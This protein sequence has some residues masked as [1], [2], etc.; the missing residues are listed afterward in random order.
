MN[1]PTM[2]LAPPRRAGRRFFEPAQGTPPP[3]LPAREVWAA[4]KREPTVRVR[5]LIIEAYLPLLRTIA[6]GVYKRLPA[7]V[8]LEELVS[9]GLF[10]LMDA[11]NAYDPERK[12]RFSTFCSRRVRGSIIDELRLMDLP[13]RQVREHEAMVKKVCDSFLKEFGRPPCDDEVLT[14]LGVEPREA[15]KILRNGRVTHVS[16]LSEPTGGGW[17]MDRPMR[18]EETVADK[19]GP[20]VIS[21]AMLRDM[22]DWA[23]RHLSRTER[24]VMI[25]YYAEGLTMREIGRV[26]GLSESRGCQLRGVSLAKLQAQA[27]AKAREE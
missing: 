7:Q 10:G 17:R 4:Y 16:S 26:L 13:P 20:S 6:A 8:E 12:V 22:R 5:N 27:R 3:P 24:L 25:L 11:I 21:R 19:T 18:V 2:C 23:L 14:R 15:R 9:A 1:P